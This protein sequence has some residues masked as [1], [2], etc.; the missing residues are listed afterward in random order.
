[1][2]E[3]PAQVVEILG[4][5]LEGSLPGQASRAGTLADRS[6]TPPLRA[7]KSRRVGRIAQLVEQLTL[8]Q[9]VQGSS[10]CAPTKQIKGLADHS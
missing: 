1:V 9:R 2:T 4:Y 7:P 10:P 6:L 8:N 5:V 3:T